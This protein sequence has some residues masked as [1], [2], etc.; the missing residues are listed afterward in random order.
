VS[1]AKRKAFLTQVAG[2]ERA[3]PPLVSPFSERAERVKAACER[4]AQPFS[5]EASGPVRDTVLRE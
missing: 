3:Y 1:A 4:G 2:P 5:L